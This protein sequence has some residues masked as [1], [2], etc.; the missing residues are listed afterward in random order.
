MRLANNIK[1]LFYTKYIHNFFTKNHFCSDQMEEK[2][3]SV[4][5]DRLLE[6]QARAQRYWAENKI[7]EATVVT[8]QITFP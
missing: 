5:R 4:R 6:M 3:S 1:Y 8:N 2:T 7:N